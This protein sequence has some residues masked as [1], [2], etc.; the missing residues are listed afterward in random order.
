MSDGAPRVLTA[1]RTPLRIGVALAGGAGFAASQPGLGAWPLALVCWVPLWWALR[2]ARTRDAVGLGFAFGAAAYGVGTPWLGQLFEVFLEGNRTLGATL[3]I[4]NGAWF[5]ASYALAAG[6]FA[7]LRQRG[8][9]SWAAALPWVA[10]EWSVPQFFGTQAGSALIGFPLWAQSADLGGPLLL[11]VWVLAANAA[12]ASFW[13]PERGWS[14]ARGVAA[15]GALLLLMSAY[16]AWRMGGVEASGGSGE[17]LRVGIVQANLDVR[18][19]RA[20]R[21]R[22]HRAHV[23]LS[24]AVLAVGP[25]DLVVWPETAYPHALRRPLPL[26]AQ[27]LRDGLEVP[28]LFGGTSLFEVDGRRVTANSAFLVPADGTIRDVYDKHLLIPVAERALAGGVV[29]WPEGWFPHAQRFRAGDA[30]TALRLG[31]LRFAV[32]LCYEAIRPDFVRR[33]VNATDPHLLV[34]LANDAWFGDTAE[35]HFHLGLARLRAIEHRRWLVRATN[36]GIS[37]IVDPAG[38]VIQETGVLR[39]A[40]VVSDVWPRDGQTVYARFGDAPVLGLVAVGIALGWARRQ[41]AA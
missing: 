18:E 30:L 6:L 40:L 15:L 31:D 17:P 3:W 27:I 9:A 1:L 34:T 7:V 36:S 32:P 10:I 25:V 4:A 5:A 41:R 22:A 20:R 33:L 13:I 24:R 16:G 28:L 26:D 29:P 37:A 14:R 11:S 38:R 2:R 8:V 21:A 19:K 39:E 12:I 35:P 23:E